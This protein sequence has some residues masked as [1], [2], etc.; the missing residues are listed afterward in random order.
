LF[1]FP[2]IEDLPPEEKARRFSKLARKLGKNLGQ[3]LDAKES[4]SIRTIS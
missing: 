4:K 2:I 1:L 3:Y